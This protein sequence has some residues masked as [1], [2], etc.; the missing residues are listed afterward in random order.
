M[1]LIYERGSQALPEL[2]EVEIIFKELKTAKST[3]MLVTKLERLLKSILGTNV[4]VEL[5]QHGRLRDNFAV[6]PILRPSK[7]VK[8]VNVLDSNQIQLNEVEIIYFM[9]GIDL[10]KEAQPRQ[11]TAILL[12]EIGHVTAH[13]TK[14]SWLININ[15]SKLKYISDILSRIPIINMLF[16]PLF[17]ITSRSLNFRNHIHEYNADKFAVKYGY[18]DDLINWSIKHGL[19]SSGSVPKNMVGLSYI[20]KRLFEGSSHPSFKKRIHA[21]IDEMKENY[22]KEYGNRKIK[23]LLDKYYKL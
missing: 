10:I 19:S 21:V 7:D 15:L 5:Q 13:I 17:I 16:S 2:R 3:K 20:L 11:V 14:L 18:G 9:M 4:I 1:Q 12:H 23:V 6:L 22:S 8:K